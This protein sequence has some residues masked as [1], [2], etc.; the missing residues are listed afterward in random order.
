[1]QASVIS[2]LHKFRDLPLD[3]SSAI[4]LAL[5]LACIGIT[6]ILVAYVRSKALPPFHITLSKNSLGNG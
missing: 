5:A 2:T 3:D 1:M 6:A 4:G